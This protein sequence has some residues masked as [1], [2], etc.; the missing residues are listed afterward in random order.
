M[1]RISQ[2]KDTRTEFR[3]EKS[4]LSKAIGVGLRAG[5]TAVLLSMS[6]QVL[7]QFGAVVE[8]SDLDGS[9]GF[10]ING[11]DSG[12]QSGFSVSGAGDVNGDGVSD[13]LV[14]APAGD[15]NGN[16]GAGESY[17]VFG[18]AV[19]GTGGSVELSDLDGSDGF[20][21]NGAD[22]SDRSGASVSIGG[23][24]NGDGVADLIIGAE[25]ADP[26][27]NNLAGESYVIF[28]GVGV[29]TDGSVELSDLDGSDG[30]V[31]NGADIGDRSGASVSGCLLYTSPSPRDS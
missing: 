10:V 30:F 19:V 28:G 29:G 17:V 25:Y 26:N 15:P 3:A 31:L 12:D 13:L 9:D 7:A 11:V 5:G 4:A 6:S 8:L 16:R 14:G 24:V 20:V 27:G 21:L 2:R 18:G 22:I 23:D 1:K